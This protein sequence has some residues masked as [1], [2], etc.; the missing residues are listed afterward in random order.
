M[1]AKF[2]IGDKLKR[3]RGGRF[4]G[5]DIGDTAIVSEIIK[6]GTTAVARFQGFGTHL[7]SLDNYELVEEKE[8]MTNKFVRAAFYIGGD[9]E[10]SEAVQKKLFEMGY[11]WEYVGRGQNVVELRG[12]NYIYTNTDGFLTYSY[13]HACGYEKYL[14]EIETTRTLNVSFTM[15]SPEDAERKEK[16]DRIAKIEAELAALKDSL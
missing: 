12:K 1:T 15:P 10:L 8:E 4:M 2:K 11:D 5:L 3:V 13:T 14:V 16:L 9:K 6:T 7:H